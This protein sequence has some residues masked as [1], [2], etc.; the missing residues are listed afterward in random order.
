MIENSIK[1]DTV[2]KERLERLAAYDQ[3]YWSF[4][5]NA[6][7]EHGHGFFQYPAM[8]VPQMARAIL[9]EACVVHPE[10]EWIR[11]PFVGSG[12]ILTEAML[13]GLNFVG[14]DINPLAVL[15]CRAKIGP[16]FISS[17]KLKAIELI[18]R[19]GDDRAFR[20]EVSFPGSTKWFRKDVLISLSKIRRAIIKESSLW[21][22]RFFWIGLA[23]A[24]RLTSNSR[25]STF[26]LH[27][28]TKEDIQTRCFDPVG[29][30]QRAIDR[31]L[32]HLSTQ[33]A[34]LRENSL[35]ERG[36]YTQ[37]AVINLGDAKSNKINNLNQS[38]MIITSPPYGDNTTTVPYGQYSY[39]PLQWI[40]MSDIDDSADSTFVKSTHEIDSRS[41]G[42]NKRQDIE[43][44]QS[45][46]DRS[47]S[48]TQL[49][50]KLKNEP[51]DR[52][53]R[54]TSFIRDLDSCFS[55]IVDSLRPGG[56]IV[57]ILGSRKVGGKR[58]PL[59]IILCE[60]L[61][62]HQVSVITSL[63]RHI[64]SKRMALKNNIADLMSSETI[65]VMR[66]AISNA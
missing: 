8:M 36:H 59:D 14:N 33:A 20:I 46:C 41:L 58:L 31:N 15:L 35:I 61:K 55:P 51:R 28:R 27:T 23:E 47:P 3:D 65:L 38:D 7:R 26:K 39:L 17:L 53:N 42:G 6:K 45:I 19:I 29:V 24:V 49:L 5:G 44:Q 12:T 60:L 66:K 32:K 62:I 25:T 64:C 50:S 11:D 13:R 1:S 18:H 43:S 56:L 22:R 37:K 40:E 30:F 57:W 10:I 54:V 21:A 63:Q 34:I 48:F 2:L 4:K 16:F 52:T 9:D